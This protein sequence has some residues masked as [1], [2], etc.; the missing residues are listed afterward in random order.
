M[1]ASERRPPRSRLAPSARGQVRAED[2]SPLPVSSAWRP[3]QPVGNRRFV[4]VGDIDLEAGGTLPGVRLAYETWGTLNEARDNAV[5]VLHALT[6]DSHVLGDAGDGHL[7]AGW[8]SEMVGPGRPI[9]TNRYYVVAPN[10]LGGCQGSTGPASPAADGVPY[11]SRFPALTVRDQVA[12]EIRLTDALGVEQWALVIGASMGGHRVLEWAVGVPDRV[13]AFAAV[14]TAAQTTGD[15]I[16]WLHS[17]IGA[18]VADPKF[19]GGDY[20]DAPDGEGPHVGLS[21]ARQIAHTTY[22]SAREL[23]TRFGRIP[24]RAENPLD[25]SGRFAVQSYLDHH[26]AKLARRFDAGSYVTLTQ[27]MITHDLGRDRGGVAAA[28]AGVTA[29]GLV[30]AVDSDRLFLPAHS[31]LIARGLRDADLHVMHSDHGHDGFLI[32]FDTLGPIVAAFLGEVA[33]AVRHHP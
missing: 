24:Q 29:R 30:I 16:A 18:I 10:V 17:Q 12:A 32:E 3:G 2:G 27:S 21:L 28:L 5:L 15:Q 14:A 11:G 23:D 7:S 9:D 25:G 6:G 19:A 13:R 1:S 8:W 4:D 20:Y 22:R 31:S 26:G 33:P